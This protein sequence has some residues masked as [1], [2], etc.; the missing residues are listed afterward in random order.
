MRNIMFDSVST[1]AL[2]EACSP[3]RSMLHP[4]GR[5]P[6]TRSPKLYLRLR[7]QGL[8]F[9]VCPNQGLGLRGISTLHT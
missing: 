8:G 2:F 4:Q 3:F 7:V 5:H 6:K 9:R 1:S